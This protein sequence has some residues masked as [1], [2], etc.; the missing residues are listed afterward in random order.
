MSAQ[1]PFEDLYPLSPMQRGILYHSLREPGSGVY[2][3]QTWCR[4]DGPLDPRA[5]EAAWG[6]VVALHPALRT[7]FD[8]QRREEPFQIVYRAPRLR[9][10]IDDWRAQT[11]EEREQRWQDLL[12][13]DRRRGFDLAKP[14]LLRASLVRTGEGEHRFLWSCHHLLVDGWCQGVILGQVFAAY[15]AFASGGEP[16]SMPAP[17]YRRYIAWLTRQRSGDA[18]SYWRQRLGDFDTATPL[19]FSPP[20]PA[21]DGG[22][23][24]QIRT[25]DATDGR[26]LEEGLRNRGLT[27]ATLAQGLWGL[28]L[29]RRADLDDVVF[30]SVVSG[31]PAE[32]P[33]VESTVGLF[34]NTL[35]VRLRIDGGQSLGQWLAANQEEEN[36]ARRFEHTPLVDVQ[37]WSGVEAGR[38]LFDSLLV[39]E[40]FPMDPGLFSA[41]DDDGQGDGVAVADIRSFD[42][43]SY[44]LCFQVLPGETPTLKLKYDRERFDDGDMAAAV[45]QLGT[46]FR[47]VVDGFDQSLDALSSRAPEA[48][49]ADPSAVLEAPPQRTL[50]EIFAAVATEHRG[51]PALVWRDVAWTYGELEATVGG[52]VHRLAE[53][54]QTAGATVAVSGRPC[55]GRVASMLA[56]LAAGGVLLTLDPKLPAERRRRMLAAAGARWLL[57]VGDDDDPT[58][59]EMVDG[60][61]VLVVDLAEPV[62]KAPDPGGVEQHSPGHRPGSGEQA[63]QLPRPSPPGPLSRGRERG[64]RKEPAP[65]DSAYLFFTSGTTGEPRGV[66]GW[67]GALAHFLEWQRDAF[68]I[69]PEDRAAH[70]TGLSFDVVLRDVFLPLVSG[71]ALHLP[72]T[73]ELSAARV[74]PWLEEERISVVHTVP[75]LARTWLEDGWL[76]EKSAPPVTLDALRRVFFAG[77]PLTDGLVER[78]RTAFPGVGEIVN[79]YGPSETTLAKCSFRVPPEPAP[80]V[81]P[82]GRPM[83]QAQALV[84]SPVGRWCGVGEPGEIILRTPFRSRGLWRDGSLDTSCFEPNP[85]TGDPDD[86]LYASGDRGRLRFDGELEILG[87]L[88]HQLKIRGVRIEP[89]EVTTV[90]E[91]HPRVAS[92]VVVGRESEDSGEKELVAYLVL[93]QGQ[94]EIP[95]DPPLSKGEADLHRHLAARLPQAAVPTAVAILDALPLGPN[96]KVDRSALAELP[97]HPFA[98]AESG[99]WEPPRGPEE[100]LLATVFEQVLGISE[101]RVGRHDGFFALGGHSLSATRVVTRVRA[102]L[103]VEVEL[104]DLFVAPTVAQLAVRLADRRRGQPPEP[105]VR[106]PRDEDAPLSF[107]QERLWFLD[108]LAPGS[109]VYNLQLAGRLRGALDPERL[110]AALQ[111]V[112]ARHEVL[113]TGFGEG[114]GRAR[115]TFHPELAVPWSR[116]DLGGLD[117]DPDDGATR[118]ALVDLVRQQAALPFDLARPPLLRA[119]LVRLGDADH[120]LVLTLHHIVAD[121]W[122]LGILTRDLARAYGALGEGRRPALPPLR[123]QVVDLAAAERR[124]LDDATLERALDFWRQRLAAAQPLLELPTDRPRPRTPSFRGGRQVVSW[125]GLGARLGELARRSDATLFMVLLAGLQVLLARLSGDPRPTV[126]TALAGRDREESEG[127]IGFFVD[128]LAIPGDV[129]AS[130]GSAGGLTFRA[131]VR[132]VRDTLLAALGHREVPFERLVE[133]LGVERS[134]DRNP[135]FQVMLVVQ[136]APDPEP[137]ASELVLEPLATDSGTARLDLTLSVSE[138]DEGA[139]VVLVDFAHDLLDAVTVDRWLEQLHLLFEAVAAEPEQKLSEL[140]RM[141]AT[142]RRQLTEWGRDPQPFDLETTLHGLFAQQAEQRPEAVAVEHGE[143]RWTYGELAERSHRLAHH[144]LG[145][146]LG[147]VVA[148]VLEPSAERLAVVLGILSSGAAYLPIE[149]DVPAERMAGI[150]ADAGASALV[151]RSEG[152]GELGGW[153][154][155]Q[156]LLDRDGEAIA[157]APSHRPALSPTAPDDLAYLIFTS[158]TT[159]RPNGVM[160]PHRGVVNTL[161]WRQARLDLGP[162]DRFL[163][164][165]PLSFDPSVWQIFGALMSGARQV[166]VT[167]DERRDPAT[168][169]TTMERRGIT[170]ADF[171]PSFLRQLVEVPGLAGLDRLRHVFAGGEALPPEVRDRFLE[172]LAGS[173]CELHNIYGPTEASIDATCWTCGPGRG[174]DQPIPIG[175]P[176]ANKRIRVVDADLRPQPIG[177]AGELVIGGE[178]LAWGYRS[179]PGKSAGRWVPDP[180]GPAG[181][182]LYRTGDRATFRRDGAVLFLGRLDHQVKI[183]G[184][185][186]EPAEVERVLDEHPAVTE[187]VVLPRAGALGDLRLEAWL[188]AGAGDLDAATVFAHLEGRLPRSMVPA[189]LWR[190]DRIPRSTAGKVDRKTLFDDP[191][192]RLVVDRPHVAPRSPEEEV[193]AE[194]WGEVLGA[195]EGLS[196]E[197]N[198]FEL[199]GDS[200]LSIQ[201]VARA[202]TR[203]LKITPRQLFEHQTIGALAAVALPMKTSAAEQGAVVGPVPS[204][205][206]QHWFFEGDPAGEPPVDP[207]HFNQSVMV[208]VEPAPEPAVL[209]QAV[210]HLLEHHDALRLRF[211]VGP[212]GIEQEAV[213]PDGSAPATVVDLDGLPADRRRAALEVWAAAT[214]RSLDLASGPLLRL[215]LF[216]LGDGGA[217]LLFAVHHLAVDGVSWRLLVE[218]LGTLLS[219]V[220]AGR[221]AVLPPKTTSVAMWGRALGE[222]A[223]GDTLGRELDT[224]RAQPPALVAPLPVDPA[225]DDTQVSD[226]E[227]DVDFVSVQLTTSETEALLQEVPKATRAR[228]DEV[229]LATL[230]QTLAQITGDKAAWIELEGHGREVEAY[231][232]LGD[233][234]LS[235]TVGWMTTL[236]PVFLPVTGSAMATLDGVRKALRAIPAHGLGHGVLRWLAAPAVRAELA[237]K[238]RPEVLFNYLGRLGGGADETLG[239]GRF[240]AA[241]ESDGLLRSPRW[242]RRHRLEI[243]AIVSSGELSCQWRFGRH[244]HRRETVARWAADHLAALRQVLADCRRGETTR[245]TPEDFPLLQANQGQLDSLIAKFTRSSAKSRD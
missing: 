215:V 122:S 161:R 143:L 244:L 212:E 80:G 160:V 55:P 192:D 43:V 168:L 187:A 191:G 22:Y 200:I 47:G 204:L 178:G 142:E 1:R 104:E 186:I 175:R 145:R 111:A 139:L 119:L 35:P 89:A 208:S 222:L 63:R 28:L 44:P 162:D 21:I 167:A 72:A 144:L 49:L 91:E 106:V 183:R 245:A 33:E 30:G 93:E 235:R 243:S 165:I 40:T 39:V 202:A 114:E 81:Q 233:L 147:G 128:T 121:A 38:S 86:L 13:E 164:T 223:Q 209:A 219:A 84:R 134:L 69:L 24:E 60:V 83:P 140:P 88:D 98:T 206:I 110:A 242:R 126:G 190:R 16:E 116:V 194:V 7:A 90:L 57:W 216:R 64:S 214:Q 59:A 32:L 150:L 182:R 176:I 94:G 76:D 127:L 237:A 27:L 232:E 14:P 53:A 71:A 118:E 61:E 73:E 241:E 171:P 102:A 188:V 181:A 125:P 154:G 25:L 135:L 17:P 166:L 2:V 155:E 34:V 6:H 103:G 99:R 15:R 238:P 180:E 226:T 213:A 77:E 236:Y 37:G 4:L 158:G 113:H 42:R 67:H 195:G 189:V 157:A 141:T 95:L 65:Q 12:D 173:G 220:E 239:G 97:T 100:E 58:L 153:G 174:T 85:A 92:A 207:H 10:A 230:A 112:V 133:G 197:S 51:R 124:A 123:L 50:P 117:A 205:P 210:A 120:A 52:L 54:G 138:G 198:F 70:L 68:G 5:L 156:V 151:R 172:L 163:Q 196:V 79:L 108:R 46:L 66:L 227:A 179:Q 136:N 48:M 8:W 132:R 149:P 45:E 193:L 41:P 218:D 36:R 184:V 19:G 217:R 96:G 177:V 201:I 228:V 105:I 137:F 18:E 229:L 82:V 78:F 131:L 23:G 87:R 211:T 224:W 159:G 169:V 11:P 225:V 74:L 101:Q 130:D 221:R 62:A 56:V 129:M 9:F 231:P 107:A 240:G 234:D 26:R 148:V 20:W 31:R 3:C 109:A 185:R 199:G 146:G 170:I 115:L 75:A 203:G 152:V 29:A